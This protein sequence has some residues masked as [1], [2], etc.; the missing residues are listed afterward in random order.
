MMLISHKVSSSG[1]SIVLLSHNGQMCLH[2][3]ATEVV[4]LS[5]NPSIVFNHRIL[6]SF[7]STCTP[8]RAPC[9]PISPL[10]VMKRCP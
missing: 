1:S 5:V 8:A 10:P 2:T 7:F 6:C 3:R 9:P 4:H